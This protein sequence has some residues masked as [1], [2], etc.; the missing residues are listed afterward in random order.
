LS[1]ELKWFFDSANLGE[2]TMILRY[3]RTW[4]GPEEGSPTLTLHIVVH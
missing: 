1:E 4:E 3:Y 2:T